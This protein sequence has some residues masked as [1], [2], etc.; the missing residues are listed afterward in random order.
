[1]TERWHRWTR[2]E[3]LLG[4]A[5]TGGAMLGLGLPRAESAGL[6][7]PTGAAKVRLAWLPK[8]SCVA[9]VAVAAERG[10]FRKHNLDV[11]LVGFDFHTRDMLESPVKGG[12]DAAVTMIHN[13][14]LPIEAGLDVRL[15]APIHGGCVRI[16]GKESA[17]VTDLA[18]LRGKTI[19]ISGGAVSQLAR[20]VFS[21]I[22]TANGL[23]PDKDVTWIAFP[24]ERFDEALASGK[25]QAAGGID[26][27]LHALQKRMPGLV[28]IASNMTGPMQGRSCCVVAAGPRLWRDEPLVALALVA[29]LSEAADYTAGHPGE[30]A[31]LFAA[32][33]PLPKADIEE[34]LRAMNYAAHHPSPSLRADVILYAR[35]LQRVGAFPQ[36]LDVERFADRAVLELLC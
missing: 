5:G 3:W 25:I 11:E 15:I 31:A 20:L 12:S 21:I 16:V 2:R 23:D 6:A 36:N 33:S 19:G 1:M 28:E 17:G 27:P 26:P 7:P 18:S 34:A 32:R 10:I 13:W 24:D 29:A 14:L 30:A 9:P 22:L 8:V 35:D 4:A